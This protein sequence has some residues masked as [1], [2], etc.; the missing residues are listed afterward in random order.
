MTTETVRQAALESFEEDASGYRGDAERVFTPATVEEVQQIVKSAVE[1]NIPLTA[2]GAG[3][4]LTGARVPHGGWVVSLR[5][6][7]RLEI[8]PGVAHTGAG[9]LLQDVQKA[10][11]RTRQF[12]GPNPT[13]SAASI[14]GII[15]TNA[16][17]SRSFK[18]GSVR[19]HV[20]GLEAV[21]MDGSV[22]RFRHGDRV[23]FPVQPVRRP[24]TRKNSAG[25][26]L[27]PDLEWIDLLCGSEGTLAVITEAD[28]RL[29]PDPAAILSAIVFFHTDAD[30]LDA[31]DAWRDVPGLRLLE[32][33]DVNSIEL[34][35]NQN[36]GIPAGAQSGL[37]VEQELTGDDDP[38]LDRWITRLAAAH[39]YENESWFGMTQ[40]DRDRF[41][42]FRHSLATNTLDRVRRNGF[43]KYG[44]D[45]AVP[46]D[47]WRQ[48]LRY[49]RE[50]CDREMPGRYV[51][52]GHIGDANA[53]VN[54]FPETRAQVEICDRL[55]TDFGRYAIELGGTVAA[56]HGIGKIKTHLL[57]AMY[58]PAEI[59]AMLDVK[60]KLDP[61]ELL[62]RGNIFGE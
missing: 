34:V 33:F 39:A 9:V 26:Y 10:A 19:K 20:L 22:R 58:Q 28:L 17:G 27:Q 12:F 55:I 60:R 36:Q 44:T 13:E 15:N 35:R 2:S 1:Q 4:G 38:E 11:Q 54:L 14:G 49:Y 45:F 40:G 29:I 21:F 32:Y 24:A 51:V 53:H 52:Y 47:R 42:R 6:F 62:G 7:R 50:Q 61:K 25:Y 48:F 16:S 41:H 23:D 37:L 3:T 59:E 18:Y 57:R 56:E 43:N 31:V 8:E 46:V 5:E 30:A